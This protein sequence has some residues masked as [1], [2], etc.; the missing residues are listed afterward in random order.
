MNVQ[1]THNAEQVLGHC[2]RFPE[3]M[4]RAIAAV[5]DQQNQLTV[6]HIQQSYLSGQ[7]LHVVTN[8]LRGSIRASKAVISGTTVTSVIGTN[9]KYAGV[10]EFGFSGT[11]QVKEHQR[12]FAS[13]EGKSVSLKD[14][15]K[16]SRSK[17]L[18][19]NLSSGVATVHAHSRKML[20][21][22]RP[23]L[24]PGVEDRLPVYA[25]EISAGIVNAWQEGAPNA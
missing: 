3:K 22:A 18:S 19:A 21:P 9:V 1:V 10:H 23:Y 25:S 4:M 5:H 13:F 11:V 2:Q 15:K 17:K 7:S 20:I 24:Q 8:R 6:G 14:A 12:R 16:I